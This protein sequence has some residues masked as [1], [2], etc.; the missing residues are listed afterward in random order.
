MSPKHLMDQ[1]VGKQV[2]RHQE[3]PRV[4]EIQLFI[5]GLFTLQYEAVLQ[6]LSSQLQQSRHPAKANGNLTN[7]PRVLV[8]YAPLWLGGFHAAKCIECEDVCIAR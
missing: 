5:S 3:Q 7:I 4:V 8:R 2:R 6:E 1:D